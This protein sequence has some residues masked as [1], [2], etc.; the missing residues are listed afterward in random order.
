MTGSLSSSGNASAVLPDDENSLWATLR[1]ANPEDARE[2][3]FFRYLPLAHRLAR[4]FAS[5]RS[6]ANPIEFGDLVQLGSAGLLEAIDRFKPELGVPFRYFGSRRIVGS[7]LNGI[8]QHSEISEQTSY[9]NRVARERLQSLRPDVDSAVS[10]GERLALI[11]QIAAELAIGL[12]LEDAGLARSDDRDPSR[13]AYETLEWKDVLVRL[14]SELD[15]MPSRERDLVR[16]HYRDGLTFDQI[17]ALFSLSKGRIS[18]IHKAAIALLRKRLL[19]RGPASF[20][21]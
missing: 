10:L 20:V 18:Q 5:R 15:R 19:D 11:G 8:A 12:M 21:A 2:R 17:A 3:L 7:I 1:S 6:A 4:H 16:L 13:S 14:E 9:R